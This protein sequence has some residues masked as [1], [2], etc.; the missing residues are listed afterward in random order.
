MFDATLQRVERELFKTRSQLMTRTLLRYVLT[1]PEYSR[2][3][4]QVVT[5]RVDPRRLLP[6]SVMV[7]LAAGGVVQRIRQRVLSRGLFDP[8]DPLP[9]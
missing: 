4:A 3:F 9:V 7:G 6:P 5:R 1:N 2:R 8:T